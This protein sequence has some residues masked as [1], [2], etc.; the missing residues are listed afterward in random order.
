MAMVMGNDRQLHVLK[1]PLDTGEQAS[2]F[3]VGCVCATT[4]APMLPR[5]MP[6]KFEKQIRRIEFEN[7]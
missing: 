4:P 3:L 6:W 7:T 5:L 2:R 1:S